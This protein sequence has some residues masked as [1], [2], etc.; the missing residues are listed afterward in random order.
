MYKANLQYFRIRAVTL[1]AKY[2]SDVDTKVVGTFTTPQETVDFI[3][4]LLHAM[5]DIIWVTREQV[6]NA[7][8]QIHP[9]GYGG[10]LSVT[11]NM[12]RQYHNWLLKQDVSLSQIDYSDVELKVMMHMLKENTT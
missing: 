9:E 5:P 10:K 6:K 4:A 8:P 1:A 11:S 12:V 2:Q 7:M 3:Q